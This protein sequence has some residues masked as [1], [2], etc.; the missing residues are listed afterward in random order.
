[1]HRQQLDRGDP[2]AGEVP[3]R[4]RVGEAGVGAAELGRHVGVGS[5]QALDVDLID[6]RVG[7]REVQRLVVAPVEGGVDDNRP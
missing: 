6:D 7:V 2:E 3:E 5:R 4:R 1:M